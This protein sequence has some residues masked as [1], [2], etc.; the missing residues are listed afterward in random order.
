MNTCPEPV[1]HLMHAYLD[2]DISREDEH[3]CKQHL[4]ACPHCKEMMDELKISALFLKNA[5][6]NKSTRRICLR[7]DGTSP[8]RKIASRYSALI[9]QASITGC[10]CNIFH[11]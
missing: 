9:T 10:R 7:R 2:G 4:A 8:E 3:N 11:Y 1:I 6:T 5:R